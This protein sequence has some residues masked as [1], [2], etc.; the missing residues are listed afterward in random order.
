[1]AAEGANVLTVGAY[2]GI[3]VGHF[4]LLTGSSV[5][6]SSR[7]RGTDTPSYYGVQQGAG[8]TWQADMRF[9]LLIQR[10]CYVAPLLVG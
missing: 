1:M 4:L 9:F 10:E 8:W 2:S 5:I 6:E 3:P 7:V